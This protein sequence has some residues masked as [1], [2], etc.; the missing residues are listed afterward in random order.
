MTQPVLFFDLGSP[1]AYLAC[2]RAGS[3]LGSEPEL[4]PVLLGAIFKQRGSGSW[5][6]TVEREQRI[7]ELE[8]RA[9]HYGLPP[10]R[11]PPDW[12]AD[13][14]QAM[15]AATWANARGRVQSFAREVFRLQFSAGA[16]IADLDVLAR[17]AEHAGLVG[18]ELLAAIGSEEVK[19][20][21][22]SATARAWNAGVR[23]IPTLV[24][25]EAIFYGDDQ[26]EAAAEYLNHQ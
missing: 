21:L 9:H 2:E 23:G 16:D 26:L 6:A 8:R 20:A 22:R 24:C 4:E 12:P 19:Q 10:L 13:G 3:V 5:S 17:C 11:W 18:T 25:D 1:Y 15:R 7:A 14:L